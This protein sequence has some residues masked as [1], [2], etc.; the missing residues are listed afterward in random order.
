MDWKNAKS[1]NFTTSI[2]DD[3][4]E[5]NT[6]MVDSTDPENEYSK[7]LKSGPE[8]IATENGGNI[9]AMQESSIK[10]SFNDNVRVI[11][12]KAQ[13]TRTNG[14]HL[15]LTDQ[16]KQQ[17]GV[18]QETKPNG[19]VHDI[20][21]HQK[22][23]KGFVSMIEQIRVHLKKFSTSYVVSD[24]SNIEPI[25]EELINWYRKVTKIR[26][27][28]CNLLCLNNKIPESHCALENTKNLMIATQSQILDSMLQLDL[29]NGLSNSTKESVFEQHLS[30]ISGEVGDCDISNSQGFQSNVGFCQNEIEVHDFD[31]NQRN[32]ATSLLKKATNLEK[33]LK[34]S[35]GEERKQIFRNSKS[36]LPIIVKK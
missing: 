5:E 17:Y 19:S 31:R 28:E 36:I 9:N 23:R 13:A 7:Y 26:R 16:Q 10:V 6:E 14:T 24:P 29:N 35:A 12:F 3:T 30:S 34:T 2:A 20:F 21:E 11:E 32:Y 4:L 27:I 25:R 1:T 18:Y 33:H 22:I 8:F 15:Q